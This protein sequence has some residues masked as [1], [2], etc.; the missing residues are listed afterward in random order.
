M[1]HELV[2]R[3]VNCRGA[4]NAAGVLSGFVKADN[5]AGLAVTITPGGTTDNVNTFGEPLVQKT[6]AAGDIVYGILLTVDDGAQKLTVAAEGIVRV[7]KNAASVAADIGRGIIGT[8]DAGQVTTINTP[9]SGK[10]KVIARDGNYLW[11]D[12]NATGNLVA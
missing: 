10:G 12:L 1:A 8:T 9:G 6:A 2:T 3:R 11:V 4:K 7:R 5:D